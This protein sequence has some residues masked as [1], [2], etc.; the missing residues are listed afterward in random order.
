MDLTSKQKCGRK[1]STI[2]VINIRCPKCKSE[3]I[4]E[5]EYNDSY[6]FHDTYIDIGTCYCEQCKSE[7][8]I[9]TYYKFSH[10]ELGE[11]IPKD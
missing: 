6:I 10:F 7:Y 3:L 2:E 1:E 4:L 11:E 5:D 9:N 8:I